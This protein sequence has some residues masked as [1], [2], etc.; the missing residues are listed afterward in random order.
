MGNTS[1]SSR[2][3]DFDPPIEYSGTILIDKIN[4]MAFLHNKKHNGENIY[5]LFV[6]DS[7]Y[8]ELLL[9]DMR[10]NGILIYKAIFKKEKERD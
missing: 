10:S 8:P 5:L 3:K 9:Q 6:V 4:Y 7:E 1:S 2:I